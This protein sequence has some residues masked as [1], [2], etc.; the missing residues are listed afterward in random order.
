[1]GRKEIGNKMKNVV[2]LILNTDVI[3]PSLSELLD[4]RSVS[5][6][7]FGGR[8][9]MID[10]TLSNMVNSGVRHIGVL[11]SNKYNSLVDHLGTGKEWNLSRKTQDLSIL[12][13]ANNARFGKYVKISIHDLKNNKGFLSHSGTD[14]IISA[15]NLITNFD[16]KAVKKLHDSN[17]ADITMVF[18]KVKPSNTFEA[19]DVFLKFNK[20]QVTELTTKEEQMTDYFYADMLIVKRA[21]LLRLLDLAES[22]GEW[23]L[24]EV[25]KNNLS[26]L[27]VFGAPHSDYF[28]RIHNLKDFYEGNMDLLNI[29]T[30]NSLFKLEHPIHTKIKDNHPTIYHNDSVVENS[31]MGSGCIID[32]KIRKSIIFRDSIVGKNSEISNSIIM[33]KACIGK[34]VELNYVIFDKDVKIRDNLK[35]SGT[36]DNPIILGKGRYI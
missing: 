25:I 6:L 23:D 27:R 3:N 7:P 12:A 2:G 16:F 8:Y 4:H 28:Q 36:K 15:P 9:R 21:V 13:G 22:F 5:T 17:N 10:F 32:G 18:K 11:G 19:H 33:Q 34:N 24:L 26:R 35:L 20:Y 30:L 31:I 1:M 29:E 14:V